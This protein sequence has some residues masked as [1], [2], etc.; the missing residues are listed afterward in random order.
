VSNAFSK[1]II[2]LMRVFSIIYAGYMGN[3]KHILEKKLKM[4]AKVKH[5]WSYTSTPPVHKHG[6]V[7]N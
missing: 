2:F 1:S 4:Y 6:V 7:L 5:V 3:G